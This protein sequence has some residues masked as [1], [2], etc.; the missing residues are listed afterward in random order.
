[1]REQNFEH[2]CRAVCRQLEVAFPVLESNSAVPPAMGFTYKGVT[3]G[4]MQASGT[5]DSQGM[6]MIDYGEPPELGQS[7]AFR[8]LLESNFFLASGRSPSFTINPA[9]G[10]VVYVMGFSVDE[11][12]PTA[13]CR[14]LDKLVSSVREW[15]EGRFTALDTHADVASSDAI[16]DFA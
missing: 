15:Q 11:A 6:L 14:N 2:F 5:D 8:T 3:I 4:L 1:M 16:R 13:L 7:E 9:S 10:H 12:D